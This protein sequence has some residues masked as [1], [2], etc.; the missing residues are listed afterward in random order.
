MNPLS[1]YDGGLDGRGTDF[2]RGQ[3]AGGERD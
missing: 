2:R 1:V 3:G